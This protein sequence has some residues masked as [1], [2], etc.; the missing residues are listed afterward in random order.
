[1]G[2]EEAQEE[3]QAQATD[4]VEKAKERRNGKGERESEY[5]CSLRGCAKIYTTK[6]NLNRHL[7][8]HHRLNPD[9]TPIQTKPWDRDKDRERDKEKEKENSKERKREKEKKREEREKKKAKA[10][11]REREREVSCDEC[12]LVFSDRAS[13]KAHRHAQHRPKEYLCVRAE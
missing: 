2:G 5:R 12:M 9:L 7:K 6:G 4:G 8:D 10:K 13:L 11:K 3:A 1:M